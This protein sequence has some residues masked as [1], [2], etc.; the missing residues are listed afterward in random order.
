MSRIIFSSAYHEIFVVDHEYC[1]QQL[2]W[3][4]NLFIFKLNQLYKIVLIFIQ[5]TNNHKIAY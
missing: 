5:T 1:F 3:E 4:K 2:G